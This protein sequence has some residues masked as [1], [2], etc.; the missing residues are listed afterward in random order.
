MFCFLAG[1]KI[2]AVAAYTSV[3]KP[4]DISSHQH[5]SLKFPANIKVYLSTGLQRAL[6]S[7]LAL[8]ITK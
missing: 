6:F 8:R 1:A 4:T 3:P 2:S 5:T 7:E